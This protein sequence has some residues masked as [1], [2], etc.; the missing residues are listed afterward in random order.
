VGQLQKLGWF[1]PMNR[2]LDTKSMAADMP[3]LNEFTYKGD[4][5]GIPFDSSFMVTTV[6]KTL[7]AKAGITSM[8]TTIDQYTADMRQLKTKGVLQYPLNIGL[9]AS[10]ETS[11]SW[12]QIT[13]AFGGTILDGKGRPQF[14][15]P[16]SPG[17]KAAEW[18]VQQLKDGLIPPGNINVKNSVSQET[19][20]AKGTV[21]STFADY[22]GNVGSLYD[23]PSS[24][25]VVH[26]IQ[27]IP[28]PG[29]NGAGP[30]L[31]NPD[32]IGIP[33][34]AKYPKAAAIFIKWLTST[35]QQADFAG[36][37]GP[38]KVM[39]GYEMPSRIS[40]AKVMATKG[41]LAGGAQLITMLQHS[42]PVFP[43]GAPS[44]YPQF[45]SSVNVNLHAAA[46]GTESVPAAIAA[47]AATA[48]RLSKAAS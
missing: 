34:Q 45:S 22:S 15:T 6:N 4:V 17:Y 16:G 39:S 29:V 9:D 27:Y 5:V 35:Q 30:N 26:Q 11:T 3:Q 43:A 46:V 13:G 12:Y 47:M 41:A 25:T 23:I 7:F 20:M 19:L 10:E 42:R 8:P 14:R 38:A 40:A 31:G 1:H 28:T 32:G 37:N 44:W 36:A 48:D 21:A 24:S 2:Y 33:T 18:M